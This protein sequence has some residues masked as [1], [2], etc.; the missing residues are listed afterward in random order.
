MKSIVQPIV[1][2]LKAE[3]GPTAVGYAMLL[4]LVF[5]ACLTGIVLLGQSTTRNINPPSKDIPSAIRVGQ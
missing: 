2:F 3:D 5:L 4:M 1:R